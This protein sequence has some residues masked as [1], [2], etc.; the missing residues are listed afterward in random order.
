LIEFKAWRQGAID[1]WGHSAGRYDP[2]FG[3]IL[4]V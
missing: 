1:L 4:G 2:C 3:A